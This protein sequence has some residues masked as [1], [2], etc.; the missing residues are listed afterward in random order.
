MGLHWMI[1]SH[2]HIDSQRR[3]IGLTKLTMMKRW[4]QHI[5]NAKH[6][7]GRG[8]AHF[9]NAI[10]KYGKDAFTHGI[11]EICDTLE[12]ADLAEEKWINHFN[13]RDPQFGFNLAKGGEHKPHINKNPWNNPEYREKALPRSLD[14]FKD[15]LF[16]SSEQK[17]AEMKKLW[18]DP[19]YREKMSVVIAKAR[20]GKPPSPESIAKSTATKKITFARPEIK[21]KMHNATLK[22]WQNPE[23]REKVRIS[24][25]IAAKILWQD[26][27]YRSKSISY[28]ETHKLC[29]KHG[30]IPIA[31]CYRHKHKGRNDS[32]ECKICTNARNMSK[33]WHRKNFKNHQYSILGEVALPIIEYQCND[34]RIVFE[35]LLLS[36]D[37]IKQY[38][39]KHPCKKCGKLVPRIPSATNFKFNNMGESGPIPRRSTGSHDNPSLDIAVGRSANRKWEAYDADRVERA[40]IRRQAGTH[41]LSIDPSTGKPVP[42]DNNT[43]QIREKALTT[44]KRIKDKAAQE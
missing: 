24:N 13:T 2:T 18:Q 40:K 38:S 1:Y 15:Y 43:M 32:L 44:F 6:K 20:L 22:M 16:M 21:E 17:S 19:E 27:N 7:R 36:S 42:A 14:N 3:Y 41:A 34:C 29:K 11:L 33:Y 12:A 31:D 10:R 9:W 5:A 30:L 23:Y 4:N 26:P 35:E 8:C 39:E 25:S 28:T 37:D